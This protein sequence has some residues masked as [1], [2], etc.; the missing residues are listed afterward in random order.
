MSDFIK[1]LEKLQESRTNF[2]TKKN[3]LEASIGIYEE[4]LAKAK[5][6]L[7]EQG[8]SYDTIAELEQEIIET[9]QYLEEKIS[10]LESNLIPTTPTPPTPSSSEIDLSVVDL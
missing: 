4:E 8:I 10:R 9:E 3:Q 5:T 1:R 6:E 2:V 7:E